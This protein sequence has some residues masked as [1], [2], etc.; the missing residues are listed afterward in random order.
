MKTTMKTP[1]H[2]L[3]N[4]GSILNTWNFFHTLFDGLSV[5]SACSLERFLPFSQNGDFRWGRSRTDSGKK[6]GEWCWQN[7][8]EFFRNQTDVWCY[9]Q[10]HFALTLILLKKAILFLL[11]KN[12]SLVLHI[13]LPQNEDA[14]SSS[15]AGIEYFIL[16]KY[17]EYLNN[18]EFR[19][20]CFHLQTGTG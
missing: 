20:A 19:N 8:L 11:K 5:L 10:S 4:E 13:K 2:R 6:R 9:L 3:S 16:C 14:K 18:R 17:C 1:C 12:L 7:T 15:T